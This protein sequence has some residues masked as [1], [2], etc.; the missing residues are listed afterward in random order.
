[1][2]QQSHFY[3]YIQKKWNNVEENICTPVFIAS[4]HN[5]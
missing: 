3:V 1:M 5:S 2:I 4:V